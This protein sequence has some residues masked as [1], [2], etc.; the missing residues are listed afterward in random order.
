MKTTLLL[1]A[2]A[3]VSG[4]ALS[5]KV[6]ITNSGFE[7]SPDDITIN[8]GDTVIFQ[9][10]SAHNAL[11]VNEVTWLANGNS[12]LDGGFSL[13]FGGGQLTGL[14]AGVHFYVCQTHASSG[15]KGKITVNGSSGIFTPEAA[16]QLFTIFPNPSN[17]K[18][19]LRFDNSSGYTGTGNS[20]GLSVE[21][22]NL[23]GEKILSIPGFIPQTSNEIDLTSSPAGYYFVKISD[24][25][26]V[27]TK[28]V[29]LQ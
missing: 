27:F 20:Q 26:K 29:L 18:F 24:G 1:F 8:A 6:T 12:A 14:A 3:L 16:Y 11:E 5:A 2:M 13:P 9:L 21:I 17:G 19:Q 15:M 22:Y 25:K 10:T 28:K 4:V 7:F 23:L